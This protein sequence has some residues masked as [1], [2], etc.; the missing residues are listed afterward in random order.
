MLFFVIYGQFFGHLIE[1]PIF[2]RYCDEHDFNAEKQQPGTVSV[3][4]LSI[5]RVHYPFE[6]ILIFIQNYYNRNRWTNTIFVVNHALCS[7]FKSHYVGCKIS[8]QQSLN[9]L[10]V[11]LM[12]ILCLFNFD[13]NYSFEIIL[14]TVKQPNLIEI[15]KC[16]QSKCNLGYYTNIVAF[17][18]FTQ[19]ATRAHTRTIF[20]LLH[21]RLD[22]T[23]L[24]Y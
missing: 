9:D 19:C 8:F 17:A 21:F 20:V 6:S 11:M 2:E 18:T 12:H 3:S 5:I 24:L 23:V 22:K 10:W 1:Q 14:L 15:L 13:C 16:M 4:N 7:Y